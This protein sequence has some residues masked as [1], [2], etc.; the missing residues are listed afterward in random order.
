MLLDDLSKIR[1]YELKYTIDE[2]LAL[3]IRDYLHIASPRSL[4]GSAPRAQHVCAAVL[5]R[6]A[7]FEELFL[8]DLTMTG[9]VD[10]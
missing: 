2:S 8:I 6:H 3:E 1:R 7:P 4:S 9:I 10:S 5:P